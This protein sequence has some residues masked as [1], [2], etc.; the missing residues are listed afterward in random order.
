ML[1][2]LAWIAAA[3]IAFNVAA[4]VGARGHDAPSGWAYPNFCCHDADCAPVDDVKFIDGEDKANTKL[5]AGISMNPQR[6]SHKLSSPDEKVH[7]CA[8]PDKVL[9]KGGRTYYCIFY[10]AGS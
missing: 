2:V 6:Y 9:G 5:H 3:M 10:P 8:T 1:K 7:I 4:L